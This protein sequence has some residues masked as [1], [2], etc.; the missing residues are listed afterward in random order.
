MQGV[1]DFY[2]KDV[3]RFALDVWWNA[4]QQYDLDVIRRALSLHCTNPDTG[5]FCPKPADVVRM[6][7]GSTK[8]AALMAWA[9]VQEA[10]SRVGSYQSVCFDDPIINRV[11]S[12]MCGWPGLCAKTMEELP[13][14]EKNFC[15]RY[16]AYRI[17]GNTVE[18]PGYLVGISEANNAQ[19]G[20]KSPPPM[21]VGDSESA[22]RVLLSGSETALI[23]VRIGEVTTGLRLIQKDDAA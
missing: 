9:K 18:H 6:V 7:G 22:K 14:V 20:F 4:L 8:D 19:N 3:S 2:G 15:E 23:P 5:Q 17:R 13:F 12:E 11:I 16:R 10:V 21:L 1:H